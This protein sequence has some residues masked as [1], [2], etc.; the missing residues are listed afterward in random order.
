MAVTRLWPVKDRL[1]RVIDYAEN[2]MKTT[3]AGAGYPD[4]DWQAIHDVLAYAQDEEK[5]EKEYFCE[6]INCD[7]KTARDEFI[8]VKKQFDKE[9]G[10]QA[11]HGYL[12]FKEQ[13]I[14]PELAQRIGMEFASR[15]W[16]EKYQIVVTTQLNTK[17]LHCHF[18][19]NSVS[20][21]DGKRCRNTSWF[22]FHHIADEICRSYGL[23]TIKEPER[24]PDSRFLQRQD[25]AGEPT[26]YNLARKALDEAIEHSFN[27]ASLKQGLNKMGYAF[28][29]NPNHKY[30]TLTIKGSSKPIR[31]YR[32][33]ENYTRESIVKRVEEN[34][35]SGKFLYT[36]KDSMKRRQNRE[37][38]DDPFAQSVR[39]SMNKGLYGL[40]LYYCWRIGAF[41]KTGDWKEQRHSA[42][43]NYLY[44][45]D[46]VKLRDLTAQTDL[47][48]RHR[49][50]TESELLS[51]RGTVVENQNSLIEERKKLRNKIRRVSIPES[52]SAQARE[53]ISELSEKLKKSRREVKLIDGILERSGDIKERVEHSV[54]EEKEQKHH[55]ELQ[56]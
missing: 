37:S 18:V 42:E 24:N 53:S 22:K 52:E 20:F 11:Y 28:D 41:T 1:S 48:W 32:L 51:Y 36:L 19:I 54:Q 44:R 15:V 2:P 26:R 56:R 50:T 3:R 40:Y 35:V 39:K 8:T 6:G 43:I 7:P 46:L 13:N 31:L 23:H 9:D 25:G 49:I 5:T 55:S 30:W 34:Y 45:D 38:P 33:G 29:F 16:G 47:L 17:H 14:T 12:S 10:I 21:A 4:A 27:I